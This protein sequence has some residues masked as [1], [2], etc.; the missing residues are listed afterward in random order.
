MQQP[1]GNQWVNE[2]L[3]LLEGIAISRVR[4]GN[5]TDSDDDIVWKD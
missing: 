5:F 4:T 2:F 3:V 1:H